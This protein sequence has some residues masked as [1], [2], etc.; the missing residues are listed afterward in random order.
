MKLKPK[1][2]QLFEDFINDVDSREKEKKK[3]NN[4]KKVAEEQI[5]DND[6]QIEEEDLVEEIN[7][8]FKNKR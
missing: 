5:E 6:E 7:R 4:K 8:Y 3:N 1:H 2:I